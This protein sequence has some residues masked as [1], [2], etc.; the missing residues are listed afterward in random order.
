M[1]RREAVRNGAPPPESRV[2]VYWSNRF[3]VVKRELSIESKHRLSVKNDRDLSEI[4]SLLYVLCSRHRL[5]L[6]L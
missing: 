3:T 5:A 6:K 2:R 4:E 1:A